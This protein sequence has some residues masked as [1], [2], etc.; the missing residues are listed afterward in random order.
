[1]VFTA[2][3]T[4]EMIAKIITYGFLFNGRDSY[5]RNSWN[6]LDFVI[7]W[8]SLVSIIFSSVDLTFFKVLRVLRVLRPLRMISRNEGLKIAVKSLLNSI[9]DIFNVFIVSM[10]FFLLFGI[11]GINYFKGM[12]MRCEI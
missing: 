6:I 8:I 10:L 1:M 9:P 4:F 7:V 2:V 11:L 12:F 5:L 3:F